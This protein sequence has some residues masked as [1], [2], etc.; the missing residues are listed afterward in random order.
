MSKYTIELI[1]R[2][3]VAS[4]QGPIVIEQYICQELDHGHAVKYLEFNPP[5]QAELD[6]AIFAEFEKIRLYKEKKNGKEEPVSEER[7]LQTIC[8]PVG[9]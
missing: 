8:V 5:S 7:S 1:K 3:R 6:T 9:L 4:F 2:Y